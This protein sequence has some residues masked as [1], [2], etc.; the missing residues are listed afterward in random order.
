MRMF[1]IAAEGPTGTLLGYV[2]AK[3]ETGPQGLYCHISALSVRPEAR[4]CGIA[5]RLMAQIEMESSQNLG[6]LYIDLFCKVTNKHAINYYR[7]L[8][9]ETYR[10]VT[11]YYTDG[12]D[13]LDMRKSLPADID[14]R[15]MRPRLAPPGTPLSDWIKT[16]DEQ[17][18]RG[19]QR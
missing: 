18:A 2:L 1:C 5:S 7:K 6:A 11:G 10:T 4:R 8:G 15:C 9:Y 3:S 16:R 17:E 19:R 12:R 14:N 13:A